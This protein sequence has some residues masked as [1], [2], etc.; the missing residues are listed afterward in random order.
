MKLTQR[1]ESVNIYSHLFGSALFAVMPVYV[2]EGVL[3]LYPTAG[4]ADIVVFSTFYCGVA[5]CFLFSAM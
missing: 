1:L 3:P 5:I 2:F 4:F